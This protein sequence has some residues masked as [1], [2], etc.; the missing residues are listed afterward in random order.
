MARVI[1]TDA[2]VERTEPVG[3]NFISR[4]IYAIGA[5][6][7]ALLITRL[8]FRLLGANPLNGFVS[9]IYSV[10]EPLIRPFFNLFNS[11]ITATLNQARLEVPTL[12]AIVVYTLAAWLLAMLFDS[13]TRR[14]Y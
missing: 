11:S 6:I 5:I 14:S 12:V 4:L 1:E 2:P 7:D 3:T 13:F 8:V 10:T 9:W